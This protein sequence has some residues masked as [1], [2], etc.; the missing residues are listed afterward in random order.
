MGFLRSCLCGGGWVRQPRVAPVPV[1]T[2]RSRSPAKRGVHVAAL[3]G[4]YVLNLT[5]GVVEENPLAARVTQDRVRDLRE[6]HVEHRHRRLEEFLAHALVI[7]PEVSP[8]LALLVEPASDVREEHCL[9][10]AVLVARQRG[11]QIKDVGGGRA[12][13]VPWDELR[14]DGGSTF[15]AAVVGLRRPR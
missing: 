7:D 14:R 10:R 5:I 4:R 2:R 6:G 8:G 11:R 9:A 3:G 13:E 15:R 1:R 12:D